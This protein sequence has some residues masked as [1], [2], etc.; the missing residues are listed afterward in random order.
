MSENK[1]RWQLRVER[2]SRWS[3]LRT[4]L[5]WQWAWN[6]WEW[7]DMG[8]EDGG[9]YPVDIFDWR[10]RSRNEDTA[11]AEAEACLERFRTQIP[12]GWPVFRRTWW[13]QG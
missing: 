8:F 12:K 1:G 10:G 2:L 7:R 11:I 9:Y 6:V 3:D 4:M 13:V 5:G